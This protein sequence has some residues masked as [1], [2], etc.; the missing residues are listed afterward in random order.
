MSRLK[1]AVTAARA[2]IENLTPADV[3][4][5]LDEHDAV[6]IDIREPAETACGVIPS[7]FLVPRGLLD[8]C[9]LRDAWD[10][11]RVIL[12]SGTGQRSA[13]AAVALQELGVREVAHLDGGFRRW[14]ADR[15]PVLPPHPRANPSPYTAGGAVVLGVV[16][17]HSTMLRV[18]CSGLWIGDLILSTT[19][20]RDFVLDALTAGNVS[21]TACSAPHFDPACL[22]PEPTR[23][24]QLQGSVRRV[25]SLS[26]G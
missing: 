9:A 20:Q 6:L 3:L 17:E 10:S 16:A 18:R 23:S 13:L 5:E 22:E 11:E 25:M 2:G 26:G 7:A 15:L 4:T 8:I 21:V 12:Y 1:D 19:A 24:T 14:V